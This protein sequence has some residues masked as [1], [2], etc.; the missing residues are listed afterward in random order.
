LGGFAI[1]THVSLL[2]QRSA[3]REMSISACIPSIS[4]FVL[5]S[6]LFARDLFALNGHVP[7]EV[8]TK[9]FS[10]YLI[11]YSSSLKVAHRLVVTYFQFPIQVC[12]SATI[13]HP[14]SR[15]CRVVAVL[16][17]S[18]DHEL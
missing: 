1:G 2:W 8:K 4:G 11:A 3:E 10:S 13:C 14:S 18:C 6:C 15:H 17:F 5:Y 16:D 12:F 9:Q 7:A